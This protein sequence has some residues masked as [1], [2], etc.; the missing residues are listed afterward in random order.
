MEGT[1]KVED[2]CLLGVDFFDVKRNV[3]KDQWRACECVERRSEGNSCSFLVKFLIYKPRL[4]PNRG[5]RKSKLAQSFP[6]FFQPW[7]QGKLS[8]KRS[9]VLHE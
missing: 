3:E 9:I 6:T 8:H 7:R 1:C 2:C 5:E 4:S